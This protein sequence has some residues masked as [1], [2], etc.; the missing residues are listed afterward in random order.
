MVEQT[1]ITWDTFSGEIF[2][3]NWVFKLMIGL[4]PT[5]AVSTS[6]LNALSMGAATTFVLVCSSTIISSLRNFIPNEVRITA[7]IMVI[8]TFV[9]IVDYVMKAISVELYDAF[10]PFIAL[11]VVNCII[12]GHAEAYASKNSVLSTIVNA[13]GSGVG[14]TVALLLLSAP[15]E[16]L[17]NGTLLG[18]QVVWD[19]F[20]TWLIMITPVGG[21]LMLA[22]WIS[23]F[24]WFDKRKTGNVT[25]T[26]GGCHG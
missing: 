12:L 13:L 21:F 4:C 26:K 16:I 19:N 23:I 25:E 14:F 1:S 3:R 5:L 15:R 22:F 20:Q 18:Y 8:S 7:Y 24:N 6:I 11:I 10:G 2:K 9:I 17:G